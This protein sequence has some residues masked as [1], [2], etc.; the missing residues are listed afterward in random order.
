MLEE[1]C[2]GGLGGGSDEVSK[3]TCH[4]QVTLPG[5][6]ETRCESSASVTAAVFAVYSHVRF[7]T[8]TDPF[9][10]GI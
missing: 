7:S 8:M 2:H 10:S 3:A 1:V 9:P 5:A 6:C 4:S